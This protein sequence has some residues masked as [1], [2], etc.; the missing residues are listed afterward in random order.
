MA[1]SGFPMAHRIGSHFPALATTLLLLLGAGW[2][3]ETPARGQDGAKEAPPA[4]DSP[5]KREKEIRKFEDSDV[6]KPPAAGGIVFTGSS[7]I[8][9][10][11]LAKSFPDLP[12]INRGFG[13]S[14]MSDAAHFA[15]RTILP[16]HPKAVVLYQE[17]TTSRTRRPPKR[18]SATSRR[19]AR[20]SMSTSPRRRS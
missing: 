4:T 6:S 19:S 3:I 5:A 8:R 7:T 2:T 16:Y 12:V 15:P 18:S 13:G 1:S 11:D 10:W 9:L 17:T 14:Q 20:S